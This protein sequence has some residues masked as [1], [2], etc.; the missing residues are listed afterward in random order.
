[1]LTRMT[2]TKVIMTLIRVKS[3]LYTKISLVC[4]VTRVLFLNAKCDFKTPECD[5]CMQSAII[6]RSVM[7]KRT[8]VITTLTTVILTRTRVISTRKV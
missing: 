2:L 1:M 6:T 3:T 4:D 7:L 5:L 8:I